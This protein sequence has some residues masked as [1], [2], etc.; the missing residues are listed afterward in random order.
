[1]HGAKLDDN[2]SKI[3]ATFLSTIFGFCR[4]HVFSYVVYCL[5]SAIICH[6]VLYLSVTFN[7]SFVQKMH[8][9]HRKLW[10]IFLLSNYFKRNI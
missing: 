5:N 3:I 10:S 1:M 2:L 8:F 7:I 9:S 4:S 6:N